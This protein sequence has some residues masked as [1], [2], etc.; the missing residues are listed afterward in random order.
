MVYGCC[1]LHSSCISSC[2]LESSIK[3]CFTFPTKESSYYSSS[4]LT[5]I[6]NI[7]SPNLIQI[8]QQI[9]PFL[10]TSS[11]KLPNKLLVLG[12]SIQ[13]THSCLLSS[14][15]IN[16]PFSSS[17]EGSLIGNRCMTGW[18]EPGF[19]ALGILDLILNIFSF[20]LLLILI[21]WMR[22]ANGSMISFLL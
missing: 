20:F 2:V 6:H 21:L 4:V 11:F 16:F 15:E 13:L 5:T 14:K 9:N 8:F 10:R 22:S 19:L 17:M 18:R 1:L 7:L 12:A 3:G